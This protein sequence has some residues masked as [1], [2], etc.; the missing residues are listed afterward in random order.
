M[1]RVNLSFIFLCLCFLNGYAQDNVYRGI[2]QAKSSGETFEAASVFTPVSINQR[3]DEQFI[4]PQEVHFLRYSPSATKNL[5]AS[6]TLQ[7]PLGGKNM[8][9]E[10]QEFVLEYQITTSDAQARCR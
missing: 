3:I 1:K 10:L 6:M 2:Q 5:N 9:L 7:I 4:D 8:Q